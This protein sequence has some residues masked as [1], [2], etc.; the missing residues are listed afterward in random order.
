MFGNHPWRAR[1]SVGLIMLLLSFIGLVVTNIDS[2]GGWN[3]WL[4]VVPV[5]ALLALWLSWYLRR[6]EHSLSLVSIWHEVLH[7]AVLGASVVLVSLFVQEGILSR[8]LAALFVLTL[9]AQAVF[10]AGIYIDTTFFAIGVVLGLFAWL[11]SAAAEYLYAISLLVLLIAGGAITWFA[12]R[13]HK[14]M[15]KI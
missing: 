6:K 10:L 9:L 11:V 14:K 2:S 1:L 12:W 15:T 4:W 13:A 5:Y 8:L 7:W 3:Y